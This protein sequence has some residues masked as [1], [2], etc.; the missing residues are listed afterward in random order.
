GEF[1][2][3]LMNEWC[4]RHTRAEALARLD[5]AR[6]PAGPVN[7]P[8]EVLQDPGILAAE[9]FHLAE[10]PGVQEPVPLVKAPVFLSRTPSSTERPP[11]RLGEHTDEILR[12]IGYTPERIAQLREQG[13]V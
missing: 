8:R 5:E 12:E 10:Y 4:S 6:I 1:F 11:P 3:D 9:P 7:S 2:S 13:I